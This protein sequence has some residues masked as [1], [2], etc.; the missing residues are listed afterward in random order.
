MC[1]PKSSTLQPDRP[2]YDRSASCVIARQYSSSNLASL[3]LQYRNDTH[4]SKMLF[5]LFVYFSLHLKKKCLSK[6]A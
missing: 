3:S 6:M 5:T 2:Q 1:K 4:T